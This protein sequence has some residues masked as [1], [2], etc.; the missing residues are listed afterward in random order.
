MAQETLTHRGL[1]QHAR[2]ITNPHGSFASRLCQSIQLAPPEGTGT[3]RR[4]LGGGLDCK[5][6]LLLGSVF[7]EQKH[8]LGNRESEAERGTERE[9]GRIAKRTDGPRDDGGWGSEVQ[10]EP[11]SGRP[12]SCT[13]P[14]SRILRS[15][16]AGSGSVLRV[17]G[18][19]DPERAR[20][21]VRGR[22]GLTSE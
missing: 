1:P 9:G 8:L 7:E 18:T 13:A 5:S 6:R 11:G 20:V 22:R 14:S 21:R 17:A 2:P 15:Q 10:R 16:A 12:G 19:G 3:Q 4:G